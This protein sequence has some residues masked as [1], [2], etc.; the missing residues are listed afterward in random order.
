MP[1]GRRR[2]R[3]D[4]ADREDGLERGPRRR[5]FLKRAAQTSALTLFGT[6]GLHEVVEQVFVELADQGKFGR[7]GSRA[8]S[9]LRGSW[10]SAEASPLDCQRW[11]DT[12]HFGC[13]WPANPEHQCAVE[14]YDCHRGGDDQ[15]HCDGEDHGCDGNY[16]ECT[17][18]NEFDYE[19]CPEE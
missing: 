4:E 13:G 3:N 10:H 6:L 17:E 2:Q 19:W 7:V 12:H 1:D 11:P 5:R 14:D 18:Q 8:A 15:F 16:E 9:A